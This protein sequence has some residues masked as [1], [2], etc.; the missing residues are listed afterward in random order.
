MIEPSL[1]TTLKK[2]K[3]L[4]A[5]SYGADSTALFFLLQDLKIEFD[6]AIVEYGVREEAKE[7]IQEAKNLA[8]RFSLEIFTTKAPHFSTNFEKNARDFRY[9]FFETLIH[10]HNYNT[11][12]TAHQLNDKL[13]WFFMQLAKGA[14]VC[15]LVGMQSVQK[16]EGY[17][18]IRPLLGTSKQELQN[19]LATKSEI[20]FQDSTNENPKY[21]RNYFR[22]HFSDQ[23][24]QEFPEGVLKTLSYLEKECNF[25][26]NNYSYQKIQDLY[27]LTR[28]EA[29]IEI[30]EI[31]LTVKKLGYILSKPQKDEIAKQNEVVVGKKIAISKT[32]THIFICPHTQPEKMEKD[33][34]EKCRTAK[35]PKK[36]RGYI[37]E[38][39]LDLRSIKKA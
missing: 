26:L 9:N 28:K 31:D 4:L 24:L 18:L 30:K 35:I 22:K 11:L 32:D 27:I 39:G 34:K 29:I 7:E 2:S 21:R 23:F 3:N 5:F 20:F 16:R 38:N 25:F 36:C 13:E 14:G 33:F 15:E 12:L 10:K 8:K 6:I 19:Y 17:T 37:Y 1:V